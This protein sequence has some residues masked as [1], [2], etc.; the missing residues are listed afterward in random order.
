M[1]KYHFDK[2]KVFIY[3][4]LYGKVQKVYCLYSDVM[5]SMHLGY[6]SIISTAQVLRTYEKLIIKG[7]KLILNSF[8]FPKKVCQIRELSV[9]EKSA[10][11]KEDTLDCAQ[12]LSPAQNMNCTPFLEDLFPVSRQPTLHLSFQT[13]KPNQT[14]HFF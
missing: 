13:S 8:L 14:F 9:C 3:G 7:I 4:K 11:S 10:F 1:V 5:Y 12:L 2:K 6:L